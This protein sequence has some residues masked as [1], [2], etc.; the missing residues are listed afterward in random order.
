MK[1]LISMTLAVGVL[2]AGCAST[3]TVYVETG[4]RVGAEYVGN[5]HIGNARAHI[6]GNRTLVEYDGTDALSFRDPEGKPITAEIVGGKYY[7]LDRMATHFF[8]DGSRRTMQFKVD[9]V[10][11][12][13]SV[14]GVRYVE[15]S[16][17][18][19]APVFAPRL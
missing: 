7:R 3:E 5:G 12:V 6:Y 13:F 1:A 8:A 2:A 4:A 18:S 17:P 16:D 14:T 19:S 11:R 10:T 9:P 15:G